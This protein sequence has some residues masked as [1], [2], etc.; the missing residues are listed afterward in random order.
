MA[1]QV[2]TIIF[3][4]DNDTVIGANETLASVSV[5]VTPEL[6]NVPWAMSYLFALAVQGALPGVLKAAETSVQDK[7][8]N[9]SSKSH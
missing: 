6:K 7:V 1:K 3:E 4:D 2:I 8:S 5:S 9:A